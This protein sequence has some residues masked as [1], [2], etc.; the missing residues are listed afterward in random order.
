MRL[1]QI[2]VTPIHDY[3][4]TLDH[5]GGEYHA[6]YEKERA[7][8][9][10]LEDAQVVSLGKHGIILVKDAPLVINEKQMV[11]LTIDKVVFELVREIPTDT[12]DDP[13]DLNGVMR[14]FNRMAAKLMSLP[15]LQRNDD[16][17][18]CQN[19]RVHVHMPG[20]ALSTYNEIQL[21]ENECSDQLQRSLDDGWRIIAACP[22]PDARRPDYI[23][24]RYNP[25]RLITD[26]NHYATRPA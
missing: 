22:Q 10:V 14:K 6:R 1:F 13:T 25:N 17:H 18:D 3:S 19:E 12:E 9:A 5:K 8:Q 4:W 23:L 2:K 20:Q 11:G 7:E 21:I 16:K 26:G 24:G 15:G